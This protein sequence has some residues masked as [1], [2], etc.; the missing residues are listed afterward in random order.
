M[1][2][3][4]CG[5]KLQQTNESGAIVFSCP[6]ACGKYLTF[7]ALRTLGTDNSSINTL[8][9]NARNGNFRSG[10]PCPECRN[11][12]RQLKIGTENISFDLDVCTGCCSL[13]FD[14]GEL[15]HIPRI[16]E[17][18]E[19]QLPQRAKEILA[20]HKV[21]NLSVSQ[22]S[23]FSSGNDAEPDSRWKYI[24][25]I[26]GLP[27]E[28]ESAHYRKLPF[29]T[30]SLVIICVCLFAYAD[31]YDFNPVL[32]QKL[33]FIPAQWDRFYGLTIVSSMF[34]H[35]GIWHLLGNIYYLLIF[36][37][38]VEICLGKVKYLLLILASSISAAAVYFFTAAN[39]H[40]PC[41]GASGFISGVIS[42]YAIMFPRAKLTFL[43]SSK[44]LLYYC[45]SI[46][47]WFAAMVW[48]IYQAWMF[49][50]NPASQTAYAAHI[51]GFIPGIVY[52]IIARRTSL[53]A[54]ND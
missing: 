7:A 33:G 32:W 40:I 3:P 28:K 10:V 41:V 37:D 50:L 6:S 11:K 52:G 31:F 17:L 29:L 38:N 35:G 8:W 4:Q 27:V 45:I 16:R 2:C 24:P 14:S 12:M 15:E 20:L 1:H 22:P 46:P 36:G 49:F 42:C 53:S 47:A 48:I 9:S 51:G 5:Q 21:E 19:D 54:K 25:L 18:H 34:L 43:L 23:A 30:W 13:W 26:L 39:P 44:Y